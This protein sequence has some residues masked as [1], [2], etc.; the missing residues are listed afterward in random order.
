MFDPAK[1]NT[2]NYSSPRGLVPGKCQT[3]MMKSHGGCISGDISYFAHSWKSRKC[4]KWQ[5]I[6]LLGMTFSWVSKNNYELPLLR[7]QA[8]DTFFQR[9]LIDLLFFLCSS[10]SPSKENIASRGRQSWLRHNRVAEMILYPRYQAVKIIAYKEIKKCPLCA[11]NTQS[12]LSLPDFLK[13]WNGLT[14]LGS[15]LLLSIG[16]TKFIKQYIQTDSICQER[17]LHRS[18]L[19]VAV[20]PSGPRWTSPIQHALRQRL[21]I[22]KSRNPRQPTYVCKP[23]GVIS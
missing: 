23:F 18:D 11:L 21:Q 17:T 14:R 9:Y 12:L 6:L 4:L 10:T 5:T 7:Q 2:G 16:C 3:L 15:Y 8:R 20:R 22:R 13:T 1:Y 19:P